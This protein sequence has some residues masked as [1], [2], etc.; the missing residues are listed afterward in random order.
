MGLSGGHPG[1]KT[2]A[3]PE[4]SMQGEPLIQNILRRTGENEKW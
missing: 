3:K 2:G 1:L 4:Q